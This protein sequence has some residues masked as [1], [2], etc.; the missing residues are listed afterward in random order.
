MKD[1]PATDA[2]FPYD[3]PF[4]GTLRLLFRQAAPALM[5]PDVADS[6]PRAARAFAACAQL[7]SLARPDQTR[8]AWVVAGEEACE[9][10]AAQPGIGAERQYRMD[11]LLRV[12]TET[13]KKMADEMVRVLPAIP[14]EPPLAAD[15]PEPSFWGELRPRRRSAKVVDKMA[16]EGLIDGLSLSTRCNKINRLGTG[17]VSFSTPEPGSDSQ[18]A[19]LLA[20]AAARGESELGWSSA[21][22]ARLSAVAMALALGPKAPGAARRVRAP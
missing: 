20:R 21:L 22:G 9:W 13:K 14:E 6:I 19:L 18:E 3:S 17:G 7:G 16:M 11:A 5:D 10:L 15:E 12:E 1:I 8:E 4:E 2:K